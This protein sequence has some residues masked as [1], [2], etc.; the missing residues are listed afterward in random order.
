[1]SNIKW[2]R[3]GK[4][5]LMHKI[6]RIIDISFD[7]ATQTA[8]NHNRFRFNAFYEDATDAIDVEFIEI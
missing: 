6:K 2:L 5:Q 3:I 1:M 7:R 4:V 8:G